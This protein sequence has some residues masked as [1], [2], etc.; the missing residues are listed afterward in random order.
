M[1]TLDR[2]LKQFD[3]K[4]VVIGKDYLV[5]SAYEPTGRLMVGGI[6]Q[7]LTKAYKQGKKDGKMLTYKNAK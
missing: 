5:N 6:K 1:R 3:D 2:L 4:Y 7:V